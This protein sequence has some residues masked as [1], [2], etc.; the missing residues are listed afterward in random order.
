MERKDRASGKSV[1]EILLARARATPDRPAFIHP[2]RDGWKTLT[3]QE[4]AQEARAIACG[5]LSLGLGREERC[6]LFSST[7]IE[8]ILAD[9]GILSAGGATTTI[10]PTSTPDD[11]VYILKDSEAAFVFV[12]NPTLL[13]KLAARREEFPKVRRVILIEGPPDEG[14]WTIT[15]GALQESGRRYD[16]AHPDQFGAA[17]GAVESDSLATL[18]YTSGTTGPPKGVELTHDCWVFEAEAI[19]A[20]EL[21][22]PNDLQYFW[23]PLA[24]VF[25]KVLGVA[26]IR[27]GF[28][29]AVDGRAEKI[30]ENLGAI[31]PTFL[32]AVPR[33]FE[34][35]HHRILE[36]AR[37]A[38]SMK[39]KLFLWALAVGR[40]VSALG[41]E[42]KKPTG[43]LAVKG[44]AADALVARKIRSIFGDRLRFVISGSAPLDRELALFFNAFGIL[45]LEG[46]GLTES[47]GATFVNR[48]EA[49]RF[50]TVGLAV[51]G[52]EVRIAEDGEILLRGRGVMRRYHNRP[53]ADVEGIDSEGWLH[54]GDIGELD[55]RGFLKITDRKKDLIK[56]SGGKYVAPQALENRLAIHC[57]YVGQVLVYGNNRSFC[58]ALITL[59]EAEIRAWARETG[60]DQKPFSE[61]VQ[62]PRV[63]ALIQ[64]AV[65]DLNA[66]LPGHEAIKKFALLPTE[67]SVDSGELTP[68]LKLKRRLVEQR[69]AALLASLYEGTVRDL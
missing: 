25:G 66:A 42:G 24:H 7:R 19:D 5:L 61:L 48:P 35:V 63:H 50:G 36:Q 53:D 44:A 46:Y 6:A 45:I 1:P 56:T 64:S 59:N 41:Q 40:E 20:L 11:C 16:A 60:L 31:R 55:A 15:L 54:T 52:M 13:S 34:K 4:T 18:I 65:R 17:L 51:P 67:F 9:L 39:Q 62:D 47:S 58:A 68:S 37:V 38:G 57:R 22:T 28:P 27:I 10:Y 49:C 69:Y 33:I 12:E 2:D 26:Q 30:V 23:L 21:L 3:W 14:G 43:W 8:W 29:T 32:C